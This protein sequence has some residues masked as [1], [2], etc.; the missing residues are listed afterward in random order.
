MP[1]INHPA[2]PD[3]QQIVDALSKAIRESL[4]AGQE[5]I[6]IEITFINPD[7]GVRQTV[8]TKPK[9]RVTTAMNYP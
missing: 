6:P 8:N 5:S 9:G 3:T 1:A 4:A 2:Q 7:T